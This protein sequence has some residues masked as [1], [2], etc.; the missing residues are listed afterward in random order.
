MELKCEA[1]ALGSSPCFYLVLVNKVLGDCHD[2]DVPQT[3]CCPCGVPRH[4]TSSVNLNWEGSVD[5][6]KCWLTYTRSGL[7][8]WFSKAAISPRVQLLSAPCPWQCPVLSPSAFSQALCGK[9]EPDPWRLCAVA[10]CMELPTVQRAQIPP[11]MGREASL[12]FVSLQSEQ[13]LT[14]PPTAAPQASLLL[15]LLLIC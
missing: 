10:F 7:L 2:P 1:T 13:E 11:G 8:S 14:F 6:L 15:L 12:R 5:R 9:A 3:N 4:H